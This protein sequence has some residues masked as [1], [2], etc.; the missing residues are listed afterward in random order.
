M[1]V[2][3]KMI[4]KNEVVFIILRMEVEILVINT[5]VNI[6]MIKEK[7]KEFIII[8]MEIDMKVNFIME[9]KEVKELF[10]IIM[11]INM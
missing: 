10:I 5:L 11:V 9:I 2:N 3:L 6:K 8:K 7:V 4:I 1:K